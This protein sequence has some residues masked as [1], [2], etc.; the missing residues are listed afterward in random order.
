[1][2]LFAAED[3]PAQSSITL[4]ELLQA[5]KAKFMHMINP[6]KNED[7]PPG[8][9]GLFVTKGIKTV[10]FDVMPQLP[11][12]IPEHVSVFLFAVGVLASSALSI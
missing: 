2:R 11:W 4:Q 9:G 7:L 6:V 3:A 12:R 5:K 1:M 8:F 10:V